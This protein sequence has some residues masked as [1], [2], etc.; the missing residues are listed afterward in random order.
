MQQALALLNEL[1][2]S[3]VDWLL[4][5]G[6]E[7]QVIANTVVIR[8]GEQPTSLYIVLEGLLSVALAS[9]GDRPV[10][11]LG[12]GEI[13]GELSFLEEQTAAA[14]VTAIESSLLLVVSRTILDVKLKDDPAFAIRFYRSLAIVIAQRLRQRGDV[15]GRRGHAQIQAEEAVSSNGA[16]LATAVDQFKALL[17]QADRAALRHEYAV[18]EA[19]A[20][21]IQQAFRDLCADINAAIGDHIPAHPQV[22]DELG[23]R[24]QREMLPYVL[25]TNAAERCY[26]KPRGYAGDF[27]SIE[28]LYQNRAIGAGRLGPVLDRCF[29]DLKAAAA[30][31]NRRGLLAEEIANVIAQKRGAV[32]RVTSLACGP[33]T[34]LFDVFSRIADP[35]QLSANLIDIDLQALA[36]VADKRDRAKLQRHMQLINA[37]LV[38]LATGRQII[39][40]KDQDLIYSIG[41]TDY[42]N[43]KFVIKLLNYIHATLRPGGKVILGNFHPRNPD[44]AVMDHILDW[45]LIHR[46]EAD[47]DRLFLSSSFNRPATN[48]RFEE[49]GINLFA[50]CVKG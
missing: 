3:D 42:F 29:L 20:K 32:A 47:M 37:N 14:S 19:T 10:G 5:A 43:D 49:Q 18:P 22:K 33:A 34:E 35:S 41:L 38:Y 31:R 21:E 26:A 25:L 16:R 24:L 13:I 15:L 1:S 7:Q 9:T 17:A 48:I 8:E 11:V 46:S 39:D 2:D 36:F 6:S 40:L 23:A 4:S 28:T 44:K 45:R 12:P 27:L 30:V 50:E